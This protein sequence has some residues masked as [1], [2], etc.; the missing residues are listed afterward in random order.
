[1]KKENKGMKS[2]KKSW[3]VLIVVVLM[4]AACGYVSAYGYGKDHIALVD[5]Q[6]HTDLRAGL[7]RGGLERVGGRVAL[8]ARV[9]L[10]DLQDHKVRSLDAEH[11][12]LIA[13]HLA[14][15][16]L[17]HEFEGIAQL[18]LI[19]GDL[20]ERFIVHEVVQVAVVVAVR[21]VAAIHKGFLELGGG[22]EGRFGHSTGH[23]VAHLGA[24]E[25]GA[26]TGLDVLELHDLHNLAV[27]LEGLA[28]SE[29]TGGNSCHID[30]PP[31]LMREYRDSLE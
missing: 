3:L 28:V 22:V 17:L 14:D 24:D 16:V 21:H 15:L 12:A 13:Q 7:Q 25:S 1:M 18:A 19:E 2:K 26:L 31:I 20:L 23:H 6:G 4:I 27:H 29:I 10:G 30:I 8:E 9:R 5:E 11:L